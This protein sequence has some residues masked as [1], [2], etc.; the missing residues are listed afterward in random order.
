MKRLFDLSKEAGGEFADLL[1][2]RPDYQE[3]VTFAQSKKEPVYSWF[4]Y[5]E[6]FSRGLV[7][8]LL[9]EFNIKAGSNVMDPFC[10]TGT[11]LL[12]AKQLGFDSIGSDILPLGV[13]VSNTKVQT[14]YDMDLLKQSIANINL[15][16]FGDTALKWPKI[17]F[18]NFK[19]ALSRYARNDLLFFKE[20][21]LEVDDPAVRNFLF[22]GL[23]SVVGQASNTKKDGG[24][25][26][27]VNKR[28]TPPVRKILKNKLSRMYKDLSKLEFT[29]SAQASAQIGD[30]RNIDLPA[31][32]VDVCITSP[33]YLNFVDYSKLYAL[34]LALLVDTKEYASLQK[35]SFRSH[36]HAKYST[37]MRVHSEQIDSILESVSS[38]NN[39]KKSPVVV[40][41]YFEDI[42]ACLQSL[43]TVLRDGALA[44]FVVGN[45]CFPNLTVDV[46]LVLAELASQV[47]FTVKEIWVVNARWCDVH[48]I[49]KDRPVRESIVILEK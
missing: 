22:L 35:K 31:E 17:K 23:L 47:G 27:I 48:G 13:F 24:V 28:H 3:V 43:H 42:Y 32:S 44:F 14:D 46:D 7:W 26:R 10:G 1:M 19:K 45:A 38:L 29:G 36:I 12:A 34:E 4:H 6:G 2:L 33:P 39:P 15:L 9:K 37:K 20:K 5:K 49:K 18:I 21:I 30:A 25:L 16:K 40:E 41:G 11:T 8:G